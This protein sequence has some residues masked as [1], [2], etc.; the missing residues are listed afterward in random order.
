MS[1]QVNGSANGHTTEASS[2]LERDRLEIIRFSSDDAQRQAI[3]VLLDR[4]MLNFSSHKE[5]EW[6][7]R[8]PIAQKLREVGVPFEWLSENA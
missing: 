8:T 7:V 1:D 6:L 2:R 5:D 4:G 3:G